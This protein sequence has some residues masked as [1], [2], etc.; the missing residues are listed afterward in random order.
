MDED[1]IINQSLIDTKPQLIAINKERMLDGIRADGS[2]MPFYSY[3]SQTVYGYPNS[4]IMLRATGAFQDGIFVEISQGNIITDSRD[5][6]SA[7]LKARYG[8]AIFG[9]GG[10]YRQE[11]IDKALRPTRD[12][13]VR[14]ALGFAS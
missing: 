7:M 11:Y 4:R 10:D 13:Y 1:K 9:T 12:M 6:K 8:G 5:S 2:E 3:V 14:R